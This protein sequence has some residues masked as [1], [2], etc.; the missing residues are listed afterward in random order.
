MSRGAALH[1]IEDVHTFVARIADSAIKGKGGYHKTPDARDDLI[2]WLTVCAVELAA[3]YRPGE[4]PSF[5]AYAGFVLRRRVID[6]LRKEGGDRRSKTP[7][8]RSESLE[9][10][11]ESEPAFATEGFDR[12]V[13]TRVAL[14]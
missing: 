10:T 5:E 1:D 12:E 8:P 4:S 2:N 3:I 13:L 6:W 11:H 14:P 7:R 9:E